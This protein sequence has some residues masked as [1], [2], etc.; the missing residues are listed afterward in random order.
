M[1]TFFPGYFSELDAYEASM[2]LA[3]YDRRVWEMM[4]MDDANN[5][6]EYDYV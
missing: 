6:E 5:E 2:E 1:D 4:M 3:E